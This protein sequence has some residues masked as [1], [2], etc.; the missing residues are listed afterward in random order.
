[1]RIT[2]SRHMH[3]LSTSDKIIP[4]GKTQRGSTKVAPSVYLAHHPRSA[5]GWGHHG[6]RGR[7]MRRMRGRGGMLSRC[8]LSVG[9][10]GG[11]CLR[12]DGRSGNAGASGNGHGSDS[13]VTRGKSMAFFEGPSSGSCHFGTEGAQVRCALQRLG[14][15]RSGATAVLARDTS[16]PAFDTRTKPGVSTKCQ[17]VTSDA[18]T[19]NP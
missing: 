10:P 14:N 3:R 4:K 17:N 9:R 1:M 8:S 12:G 5:A 6:G 18:A 7:G 11:L 15:M 2:L 16:S 13:A 19:C